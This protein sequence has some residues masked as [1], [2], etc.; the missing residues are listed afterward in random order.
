MLGE[1]YTTPPN[2]AI[3]NKNSNSP[4]KNIDK[5]KV[6]IHLCRN[7]TFK[8]QGTIFFT[9]TS[10][11]IDNYSLSSQEILFRHT[12]NTHIIQLL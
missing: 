7:F 11:I 12:R 9:F 2:S 6:L 5:A 3:R 4:R 1:K 10:S 8:L